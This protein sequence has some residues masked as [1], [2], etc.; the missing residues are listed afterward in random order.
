MKRRS[1]PWLLALALFAAGAHAHK[2]SDAYLNLE[3]DG[4][5]I[6]ARLDVAL[7]DLD[8]DLVLDTDND[9]R[10]TWREVRTR[11]DRIAA[12]AWAGVRLQADGADCRIAGGAP[13]Q[14]LDD[15]SDGTYVVLTR[16]LDCAAP[17]RRIGIDYT[18]FEHTDPTH[19]GIVRVLGASGER[20]A[21]LTPGTGTQ[22]FDLGASAASGVLA[23]IG[24]G[25]H[26]IASGIDHVLFLMALLLPS[27]LVRTQT[28]WRAA[29][30]FRPVL[31]DVLRVVTAFTVA[32]SITLALAVFDIVN[33]PSRLVES[34]IAASVVVAALNNIWPLVR[35]QRWVMTFCF[36]LMHGFG[37]ASGLK[38]LGLAQGS[39]AGPLFGFNVGVELGQAAVVLLFLPLAWLVRDSG[40]YRRGVLAGGSMAIALLAA[41]WLVQRAAN[42]QLI[43]LA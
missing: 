26:H 14:R 37:F 18:L 42:V 12:L 29:S 36:G 35:E 20:E 41:I 27:V 15:H 10:L 38:D 43:G 33:P 24:E 31:F 3:V 21:V 40:T 8:R 25:V 19:R 30:E 13:P 16:S 6:E 17:V 5:R 32:H 2:P 22:R 9:G 34:A 7:R 28:G 4:S 1:T 39:L 23:F 11:W